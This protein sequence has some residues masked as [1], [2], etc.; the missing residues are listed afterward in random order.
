MIV[1]V[2]IVKNEKHLLLY[3]CICCLN[4]NYLACYM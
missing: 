1:N 2:S 3:K 4:K